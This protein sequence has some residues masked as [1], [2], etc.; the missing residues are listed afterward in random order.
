MGAIPVAITGMAFRFPGDLSTPAQFWDVL[1]QGRDSVGEIGPER[2]ATDSLLNPRRSEPG[3]SVTFSAGVLSRIDEFDAG[4]FG[5]SPREAAWLD[6]QQRLLLELAW[7]A[8]ENAGQVP[9]RL[10]GSDCAVF[11]GISGLDY[12][13]RGLDDLA[14]MSAHSMTGNTMSIAA[15]RLSYVFDLRGPSMAVDTACSSSLVALHQ[16]C[17][18]LRRGDA[19]S[20]LVGGVNLLLHPYPFVGFTKAS[21]LSASGRCRAFDA[22]GD[23]YVRAEGGAVLL[24][25]P[26]EQALADGDPVEAVVL[27][28]GVNAD[29]GR[30]T[31]I[32][33][34]SCAG[35]AD[36]MRD[37]SRLAGV[38]PDDVAYVE[39]HGTGT[40]VGDPVEARAIG[41]VYGLGR[42]EPLPIGS[43]KTNLGHL[44]A[45]SGM[46]G[47][48]KT[49]LML[50][51]RA[52][53]PSLHF[54]KPNPRIDFAGLNIRV[55]T[56]HAPLEA[57]ADASPVMG[58]N[59]FGF[60][61]ANAHVLLRAH[62]ESRPAGAAGLAPETP[63]VLSARS[64]AALRELAGRFAVQIRLEGPAGYGRIVRAAALQ[65]EPLDR[66]LALVAD[67][68][69]SA[70]S[71]LEAFAAGGKP[72]GL[73]LEHAAAEKG[74]IAFV[75]TGNGAQWPGMGRR[76]LAEHP[77]FAQLLAQVDDV[78]RPRA[79]FSVCEELAAG[80]TA[81]RLAD[82]AFAQ[83]LLFALQ[84]ALT[85]W[86]R[87]QGVEADAVAGHSVGEVAAA[88]AGGALDLEQAAEVI[89]VRS[90]A[91]ALTQG[92]GRMAAFGL[93]EAAMRRVI[94]QEG[95]GTVEIAAVN[96]PSA[97][98]VCGSL[99]EIEPLVSLLESRGIFGRALDLD[100][101]FHSR[102]M[103]PIRAQV[104]GPLAS[105]SPSKGTVPFISTVTGGEIDGRRLDAAYWWDNVRQPVRFAAAIDALAARGCRV[106][107]EIGPHALLQ[108]NMADCLRAAKVS[109][110]VLPTLRRE[111]DG[112]QRLAEALLRAR[113]S[114][115]EPRLGGLFAEGRPFPAVRLPNYPWQRERYWLARTSEALSLFDRPRVHPLLGWRLQECEA[116][117]ENTL[118]C[119]VLPYLADHRVG[120]ATLL[121]ASAFA[122]MGLAAAREWFGSDRVDVQDLDILAPIVL[123]ADQARTVRLDF[124][125]RDGSF[126]LSSRLRLSADPWTVNA[127]GRLLEEPAAFAPGRHEGE[128]ES[129]AR[130]VGAAEHYRLAEAVGL[131]YGPAF[132][133][134]AGAKVQGDILH[135]RLEG[136]LP[137][138]DGARYL[139]HP[140]TLDSCFQSLVNFFRDEIEAGAGRPLLPVRIGRL[141][142]FGG[143]PAT[144]FRVHLLRRSRRSAVAEFELHDAQGNT[145][146]VLEHCRFRAAMLRRRAEAAAS[147]WRIASK[148]LAE[149]GHRESVVAPAARV[150]AA[151]ARDCLA[152]LEIA[153]RREKYFHSGVP[154]FDALVVSFA[155]GAFRDLD[156]MPGDWLQQA[157]EAPTT[158]PQA[159]R[160]YLAWLAQRL[161]EASL[162]SKHEGRWRLDHASAPP[163][164]EEIWRTL[165]AE[166]PDAL[167]ELLFIGRIGR[168]LAGLLRSEGPAGELALA[169]GSSH[170]AEALFDEVPAYRGMNLALK[171]IVRAFGAAWP[172]G[173]L[174]R[175]LEISGGSG[176]LTRQLVSTLPASGTDYVVAATDPARLA[177]LQAEHAGNAMVGLASLS[178]QDLSMSARGALPACFDLIIVPHWLHRRPGLGA[179]LTALRRKL[180]RGGLLVLAERHA[181]LAADFIFGLEASWWQPAEGHLASSL[182]PARSWATLLGDQGF[183]DIEIV[184]EQADD[185]MAGGAF[186]VLARNPDEA[187]SQPEPAKASW[188]LACEPQ[189]CARQL[190]E[191]LALLLNS[192]GQLARVAP[193]PPP[194]EGGVA[195]LLARVRQESG[196]LD[197]AVHVAAMGEDSASQAAD[198][199]G[200]E[201]M[202]ATARE[203]ALSLSALGPSPPRLWLVTSGGALL[204]QPEANWAIDPCQGALWGLGRVLMNECPALAC[205]LVDIA[206]DPRAPEAA[207]RLKAELLHPDGESEI[208]LGAKGRYGLRLRRESPSPAP[209]AS[210]SYRLDFAAPGQ[211]R[212]LEWVPVVPRALAPDEVEVRPAVAGL[213]FRD[214]MFAM[215]LLPDEA[216]EEGFSGANLG[217]ELAGTVSRVGEAVGE[218]RVGDEVMG[219]GPACFSSH[220]IT[221]AGALAR[222]PH[223]WTFAQAATVPT[224]FFTAYYALKHLANVQPG[225]RVLVH[226]AAGGVG[227]AAVQVALHLG[228]EIIATAGTGEKRD[229]VRL[230]GVAHVID[231]RRADFADEV[232]AITGGEGVD[233]VLNSLAGEAVNRNLR[234]LKPFGRFLELGKRDYYEN[235]RIGLRPFKDNISYFG[236]DADQ[237]LV[238]RPQLAS[239]LFQDV[240]DLFREEILTPLPCRAFPASRVVE[241]FRHMQQS[242]H[243]GKVVVDFAQ[244]PA[245]HSPALAVA[246][247]LRFEREAAYLVTGGLTGFGLE[248][249]CWLA[250]RGAGHLVLVG[251]R[252]LQ[253]PGARE[254]VA[255]IE[256]LGAQVTVFACDVADREALAAV[257]ARVARDLPRLRGVLHA[258]MVLDDALLPRLDEARM[259]RVLAPKIQGAWNLHE[260]TLPVSL[261]HF[262]LY[263]SVTTSLGSPGQANYVAG[264]AFLESLA[265]WRR[266]RGL[267]GLCVAWGPI[268]DVGVLARDAALGSGLSA[269]LGGELLDSRRAL[270]QLE[271]AVL[272][273]RGQ[274]CVAEFDWA[275]LSRILPAA[276][277]SRFDD[278]RRLHETGAGRVEAATDI[279]A[280]LAGKSAEEILQAV[281]AMVTAEVAQ[282]LSIGPERLEP[283]QS[284]YD[285][286]MDSLMAVELALG[287]E[288]RFDIRL[289]AM[290]LAEGPSIERVSARVADMLRG[291]APAAKEE[292]LTSLVTRMDAQH[293]A[294]LSADELAGT[295]AELKRRARG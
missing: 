31:G 294:G 145:V 155:Y 256:A 19:S 68:A 274:A 200:V 103:E 172:S 9:S 61:G 182:L 125:P 217:L 212:N 22:A 139:L 42:R 66:R 142:H 104:E 220:V 224:A 289:P 77:R 177:R 47:L 29:G 295:V 218:F 65:R 235:T 180:A 33:I 206:F 79:G 127:V 236:I 226:G 174:L 252:G 244:P 136:G 259:R 84:V 30:K 153:L 272:E 183:D 268:G 148:P 80:A 102:A 122:E 170:H 167:P 95:C 111:D 279:R 56:R 57:D 112:A 254:A 88:W 154:L 281:Q 213:N 225:E 249:A 134:F 16:A 64:E 118:D 130:E 25:K 117:W 265:A 219:F 121:A 247:E 113:L 237:L 11:V 89:C 124:L 138:A 132:R 178:A 239:R 282:I 203:L 133:G 207:E 152:E 278:L 255:R 73:V 85:R 71:A 168:R 191:R 186:L 216:V 135:G 242:R 35:Q 262:I 83:P 2:W 179:T 52:L 123:D 210:E 119:A 211:L 160:P 193:I 140:V 55:V 94:E 228:A 157:L 108:R 146:A 99:A 106:F 199:P 283:A 204:A 67:D 171:E 253:T 189:A 110:R 45:A 91:Q 53:A 40:A 261:E 49:V 46:A 109:G 187:A 34:P 115:A 20:A 165:L 7:E 78:L 287:L 223:A 292:G 37:V 243:I 100:Y 227:I 39:A 74:G 214:V 98:T 266:G 159:P 76:L 195:G 8:M 126:S 197:H 288:K 290:A 284:L 143:G 250:A 215:G 107:V 241:A 10:A 97:V 263:S 258:A 1:S 137:Q 70:A 176:D 41:E 245:C 23:G 181:D 234:A 240:M 222:K 232:L 38:A 131:E 48:V 293:D 32:T 229:F 270:A 93:S 5:I 267:P 13:M 24:L 273:N 144:G 21:M 12:G 188:L 231:S 69:A 164:A 286:G 18:A 54:D 129:W 194:G 162:L 238:A 72:P 185:V 150:L 82:T 233:V 201:R 26:L 128:T 105:L 116:A 205:T 169:I 149:S 285:L 209:A 280:A 90:R 230:T 251:R 161:Q 44:E 248:S 75:Y 6:P 17:N 96:S 50:K 28:S 158:A 275:K 63:L 92:A 58:V 271:R 246:G 269:R 291:A 147:Q 264:N 277:V 81:G 276:G 62:A 4:F 163:P 14:G 151:K 173:R 192:Q 190:A 27:A 257:L 260:L 141:R 208:V 184:E 156:A 15:N 43:V 202:L 120:G 166:F 196:R 51:H 221:R 114:P 60:G 175:I 59:S 101:A 86:L 87:E 3:R 198:L 36:L